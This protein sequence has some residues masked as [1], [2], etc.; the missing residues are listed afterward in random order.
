MILTASV[1]QL[2]PNS[3]F[4]YVTSVLDVYQYDTEASDIAASM[5]H[6]AHWDSTYSPGPPFATV[7][8][9]AQLAPDGKIYIGTGNSTLRMHVINDPDEPGLGL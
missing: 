4:L 3:R 5:V 8:D 2:F 9:I 1:G 6:I 7:F